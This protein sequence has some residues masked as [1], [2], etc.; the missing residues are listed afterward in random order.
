MKDYNIYIN[1]AF[2]ERKCRPLS[3]EYLSVLFGTIL[4]MCTL[5]DISIIAMNPYDF[6][7]IRKWG[8]EYFSIENR[9]ELL[10]SGVM[11]RIWGSEIISRKEIPKGKVYFQVNKLEYASDRSISEKLKNI[12][13]KDSEDFI[14]ILDRRRDV[15]SLYTE[16]RYVRNILKDLKERTDGSLS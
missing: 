16:L 10:R 8:M 14:F 2:L 12:L 6:S 15:L 3:P 9:R 5:S 11:G 1:N 7:D 4:T 13:D